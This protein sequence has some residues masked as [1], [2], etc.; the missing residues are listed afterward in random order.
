M[1]REIL[2]QTS[3]SRSCII[4]KFLTNNL[5]TYYLLLSFHK[6]YVVEFINFTRSIVT[7]KIDTS[8]KLKEMIYP[9]VE[10]TRYTL[11]SR[12]EILFK[13]FLKNIWNDEP[14][15]V[16]DGIHL[17]PFQRQ[18]WTK[19]NLIQLRTRRKV[20]TVIVSFPLRPLYC[21]LRLTRFH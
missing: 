16:I 10:V 14:S 3:G 15:F 17:N 13:I 2:F 18:S 7:K 11:P 9:K 21:T 19:G 4:R 1:D 12:S 8:V 5:P 20:I 6:L